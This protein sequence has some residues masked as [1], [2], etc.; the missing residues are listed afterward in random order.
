MYTKQEEKG[1]LPNR[2]LTWDRPIKCSGVKPVCG[3]PTHTPLNKQTKLCDM[4]KDVLY[5][6]FAFVI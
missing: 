4:L 2:F 6:L 3:I 5:H 1:P